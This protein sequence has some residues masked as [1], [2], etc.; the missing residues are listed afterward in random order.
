MAVRTTPDA[1]ATCRTT[2]VGMRTAI[3]RRCRTGRTTTAARGRDAA[4]WRSTLP[5][6]SWRPGSRSLTGYDAHRR[7]ASEARR[8]T[9]IP[10]APGHARHRQPL[11]RGLPRRGGPRLVHAALAARAASATASAATSS[12]CAEQDMRTADSSTCRTRTSPTCRRARE[13]FDDYVEAV[14]LGAGLCAR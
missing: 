11:H 8:A 10:R 12:S 4:A 14:E 3:E 7:E 5:A 6:T 9:T 1:R 13:H 2:C